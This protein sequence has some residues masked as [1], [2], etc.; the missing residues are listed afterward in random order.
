M[1]LKPRIID[2]LSPDR[3]AVIARLRADVVACAS[4]GPLLTP[5]CAKG[6]RAG[7]PP[8]AKARASLVGVGRLFYLR[9]HKNQSI[10][11]NAWVGHSATTWIVDTA[12]TFLKEFER[13]ADLPNRTKWSDFESRL[14]PKIVLI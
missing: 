6:V 4:L 11:P 5:A 8:T 1:V 3:E 13:C 2:V 10:F 14:V 7:S 12:V 9:W